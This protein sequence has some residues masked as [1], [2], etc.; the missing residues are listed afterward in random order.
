MA[1]TPEARRAADN[2]LWSH[3]RATGG[4][5]NSRETQVVDLIADLLLTLPDD[6]TADRVAERALMHA[7][8]DRS[9][10]V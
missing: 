10:T 3:I 5:E 2:A 9:E 1:N 4:R 7:S 8:Q 6:E